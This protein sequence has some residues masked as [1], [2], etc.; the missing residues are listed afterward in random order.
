MHVES[1]IPSYNVYSMYAKCSFL[2]AW[3]AGDALIEMRPQEALRE[4]SSDSGQDTE[5]LSQDLPK[6]SSFTGWTRIHVRF[7]LWKTQCESTLRSSHTDDSCHFLEAS[8]KCQERNWS[9]VPKMRQSRG[10]ATVFVKSSVW[11]WSN[12]P[13]IRPDVARLTARES[14]FI[15]LWGI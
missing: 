1:Y 4:L 7:N 13:Q 14:P 10:H 12:I 15:V 11:G 9:L 2:E 6:G 8:S 3:V 5:A